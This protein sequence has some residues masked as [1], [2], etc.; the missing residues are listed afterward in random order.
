MNISGKTDF[1][2]VFWVSVGKQ[3]KDEP[4]PLI[5]TLIDPTLSIFIFI[6]SNSGNILKVVNSN[7][8][9]NVEISPEPKKVL[10]LLFKGDFVKLNREKISPVEI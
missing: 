1:R 4:V 3:N 5:D 2:T 9:F 7:S 8:F 6:L 10:I